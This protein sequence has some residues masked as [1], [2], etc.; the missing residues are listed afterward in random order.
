MASFQLGASL[1]KNL[2]PFIG[3]QGTT[4]V[5]LLFSAIA[6]LCFFRPW[7]S[8]LEPKAWRIITLY[9]L[10]LGGM[11]LLFY[12]AIRTVPLGVAVAFE[13]AGP[14]TV[15]V[16]ASRRVIDFLWISLA[17][18]GLSVLLPLTSKASSEL[19][20]VGIMYAMGSAL[21][22]AFYIIFGK[23][24]GTVHGHR[25]VAIA[26]SVAA[27][28]VLPIG[29][30][31][32]GSELFSLE[33]L[34]LGIGVAILSS[35]IPYSL[36]MYVLTQLPARTFGTLLSLEPAFAAISGMLFL[37]ES[38]SSKQWIA[39]LAI[40]TASIGITISRQKKKIV[41]SSS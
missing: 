17:C 26:V 15:A 3:A 38:L 16:L 37:N 22:C 2:F 24:A 27:T 23:R 6:L 10:A 30:V 21:C 28:A 11:N 32:A 31:Q 14:L 4:A 35:A 40:I 34:P 7:R 8:K 9:G 18:I 12:M 20:P 33:I 39:I 25:I 13:F 29:I 41:R 5:R 36:E 1:A 19:D